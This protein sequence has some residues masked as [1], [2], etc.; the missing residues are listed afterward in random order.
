LEEEI[1]AGQATV[2]K[3]DLAGALTGLEEAAL[4]DLNSRKK[5]TAQY[6]TNAAKNAKFLSGRPETNRFT[7]AI[8]SEKMKNFN[9]GV[10]LKIIRSLMK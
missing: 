9:P 7:A 3:E 5:C 8:V 6:A 1:L 2:A 4:E 10:Q